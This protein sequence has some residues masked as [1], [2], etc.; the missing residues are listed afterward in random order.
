MNQIGRGM[1]GTGGRRMLRDEVVYL[2]KG[3]LE[4]VFVQV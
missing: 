1:R 4:A 3:C 2:V